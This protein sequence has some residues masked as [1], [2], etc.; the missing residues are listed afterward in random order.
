MCSNK[1]QHFNGHARAA[2]VQLAQTELLAKRSP[3]D[4]DLGLDN[5]TLPITL[6]DKSKGDLRNVTG[7]VLDRNE[8]HMCRK[9]AREGLLKKRY[10]RSQSDIC[11]KQLYRLGDVSADRKLG[12]RQ[13]VQ[14]SSRFGGQG[15]SK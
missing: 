5:V 14:Q 12:P 11:T 8:N 9:D 13:V 4:H 7:V 3:S 1:T 15:Y 6:T 2:T 10:S